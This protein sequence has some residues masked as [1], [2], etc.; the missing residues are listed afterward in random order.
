MAPITTSKTRSRAFKLRKLGASLSPDD[1]AWLEQ[2]D[3]ALAAHRR[4]RPAAAPTVAD[5]APEL[6]ATAPAPPVA[7]APPVAQSAT[8]AGATPVVPELGGA[9]P[10]ST[11]P[12]E[13]SS[14]STPSSSGTPT[15]PIDPA[16]QLAREQLGLAT[17]EMLAG[18][19]LAWQA[20]LRAAGVA[21]LP[22]KFIRTIWQPAAARVVTRY[23]P[24]GVSGEHADVVLVAS[25]GAYSFRAVRGARKKAATTGAAGP[26]P[27]SKPAPEAPAPAPE[28]PARAPKPDAAEERQRGAPGPL[29]R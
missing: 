25:V 24:E 8:W 1:R 7:D 19:L 22:D 4:R 26:E 2:Y 17:A 6:D 12:G 29:G 9:A 14:S 23:A 15:A 5:G 10:S 28:A 16:V 11:E 20:E 13:P 3:A 27:K 21:A 18:V